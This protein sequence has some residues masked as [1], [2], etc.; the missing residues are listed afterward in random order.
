MIKKTCTTT[1][2]FSVS[3]LSIQ[4]LATGGQFLV[5]DAR[6]VPPQSCELETWFT[7]DSPDR[8]WT[9]SPGCNF[10]GDS[11]W[12]L[13]VEY[14]LRTDDTRAIGM[15]Y[16]RVLWASGSGPALA[17]TA[18]LRYDRAAGELSTYYLNVPFSFQPADS[19]TLHVNGG[20]EHDRLLDDSYATWGLAATIK[21]VTG[22]VWIV[23]LFDDETREDPIFAAGA[24]MH[25]GST[26]WTLDLGLARDIQRDE[27]AYT[28]GV[29]LPRLF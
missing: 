8:I 2:A 3:L 17:G 21:P 15:E 9:T 20:V 6:I 5:D 10:T 26:R 28:V 1:V 14:D 23:E 22:P 27:T 13:P 7:S 29:N 12:T 16:K 19:I 25:I 4:C 24:R 18:G 11:G